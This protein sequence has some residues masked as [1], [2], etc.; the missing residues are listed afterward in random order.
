MK[1]L[2]YNQGKLR[3]EL[4]PSNALQEVAKVF[5]Y[6]AE[7]Y[8]VRNDK[9]EVVMDGANNWKLGQP[10]MNVVASAKRHLEKFVDGEDV[11]IESNCLHVA[12]AVTNLMFILEFYKIYPQGDN[13]PHHYLAKPKIGLDLDD[14]V[15]DFLPYWCKHFNM[16]IP[17]FW[18]FDR[19]MGD[20]FKE[21]ADDKDFWLNIPVKTPPSE[22]PFEPE[23]Y[24]TSRSIPTEWTEEWL[25]K[26]GFPAKKVYTVP[27][28][29][30]KVAAAK[31]SGVE[32]FIDDKWDNF[33]DLTRNGICCYLFDAPHNRRYEVGY[34]RIKSLKELPY[35]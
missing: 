33:I 11:D 24:I 26:N 31:E 4:I 19:V 9:D 35:K 16:E 23:C 7:K 21:V 8:T 30:S 20:K 1:S 14:V 27:H 18:T 10:W 5:T 13:R 12:M 34:R 29:V 2:R 25:H 32:I 6:G 17:E 22:I 3:L 15:I 28:G